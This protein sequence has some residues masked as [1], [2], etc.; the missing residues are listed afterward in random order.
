MAEAEMWKWSLWGVKSHCSYGSRDV[1]IL[2]SSE[3]L[4]GEDIVPRKEGTLTKEDR[5]K[6]RSQGIP[7]ECWDSDTSLVEARYRK[8]E[9][10]HTLQVLG[11]D[12][13]LTCKRAK[14][15][16]RTLMN[17]TTKQG[18]MVMVLFMQPFTLQPYTHFFLSAQN[19]NCTKDHNNHLPLPPPHYNN[20][21]NSLNTYPY[22]QCC[23]GATLYWPGQEEHRRLVLPGRIHR[24]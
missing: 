21:F 24:L 17:N 4:Q 19:L 20:S 15:E 14:E 18:G 23:S 1:L 3:G 10:T 22:F 12:Q 8:E 5:D 13:S 16:I 2:I 6:L 9:M 11:Y 7:E